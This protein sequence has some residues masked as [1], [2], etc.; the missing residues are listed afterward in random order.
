VISVTWTPFA[1]AEDG[2]AADVMEGAVLVSRSCAA[3]GAT[4]KP[5]VSTTAAAP[6]MPAAAAFLVCLRKTSPCFWACVVLP[7]SDRPVMR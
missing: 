7:M 1:C 3:E 6:A 5:A 2:G 4:V